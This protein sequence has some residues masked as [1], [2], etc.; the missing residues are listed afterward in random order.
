VLAMSMALTAC[1]GSGGEKKSTT[2]SSGGGEEKKA[3]IKYA[4]KQVLNRTENQEIP[5]MDVSKSTDTLGSQ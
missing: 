3:E 2:T 1:S 4:A 5:T